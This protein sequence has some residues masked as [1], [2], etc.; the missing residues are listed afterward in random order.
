[1]RCVLPLLVF[2]AGCAGPA[3]FE[4]DPSALPTADRREKELKDNL[5]DGLTWEEHERRMAELKAAFGGPS[6]ADAAGPAR[7]K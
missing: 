7:G 5:R 1:M 2:V 4:P 6:D 3:G